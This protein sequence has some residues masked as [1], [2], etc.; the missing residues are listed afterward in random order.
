MTTEIT[1]A[2]TQDRP[3]AADSVVVDTVELTGVQTNPG[4]PA[5]EPQPQARLTPLFEQPDSIVRDAIGDLGNSELAQ[6]REECRNRSALDDKTYKS[7][8]PGSID[9]NIGKH[10]TQD[11]GRLEIA[12]E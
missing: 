3:L 2:M 6:Y 1:E 5:M 9:Q 4:W 10:Q 8:Q 12:S 7:Q 11:F